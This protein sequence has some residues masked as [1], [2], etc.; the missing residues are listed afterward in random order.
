MLWVLSL[1]LKS[2]SKGFSQ[3]L[4]SLVKDE[5]LKL[6]LYASRRSEPD[7][8]QLCQTRFVE[9]LRLAVCTC[10]RA[11]RQLRLLVARG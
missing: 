9:V 10:S 5:K 1:L 3:T 11:G 7:N 2:Q 8:R 4:H 6:E